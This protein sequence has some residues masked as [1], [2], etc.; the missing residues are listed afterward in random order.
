MFDF[1]YSL[2]IFMN[3][4]ACYVLVFGDYFGGG[5]LSCALHLGL[6][7]LCGCGECCGGRH[8]SSFRL[9]I[10]LGHVNIDSA[11]YP[12][13]SLGLITLQIGSFV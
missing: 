1:A 10:H 8:S 6:M 7:G 13:L 12:A 2:K 9:S 5:S 3:I 11:I 4:Y